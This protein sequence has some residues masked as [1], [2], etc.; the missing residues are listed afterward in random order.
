MAKVTRDRLMTALARRHPHFAW[1]RNSGYGTDVHR[2]AIAVHG[3]TPH[4]RRSF[5]EEVQGS[6][7]FS[8]DVVSSTPVREPEPREELPG[9]SP[10]R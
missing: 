6:L 8:D 7:D 2:G 1:E 10:R 3:L 5:C 9:V 4:H